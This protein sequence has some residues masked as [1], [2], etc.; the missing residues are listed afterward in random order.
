MWR[1]TDG[2]RVNLGSTAK[3]NVPIADSARA[4]QG[5]EMKDLFVELLTLFELQL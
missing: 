5:G 4:L 3:E 2:A 1:R